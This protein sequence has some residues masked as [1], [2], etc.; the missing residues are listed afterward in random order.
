[1]K[2]KSLLTF[3]LIFIAQ[4]TYSQQDCVY[5]LEEALKKPEAVECLCLQNKDFVTLPSEIYE[6]VNLKELNIGVCYHLEFISNDI[7]RLNK[8]EKLV[9][10]NCRIAKLTDSISEL[11][12]LRILYLLDNSFTKFPTEILQCT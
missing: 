2:T 4:F 7:A 3:L 6:L 8:L 9:I 12:E 11:K 5:S 10:S 1:M